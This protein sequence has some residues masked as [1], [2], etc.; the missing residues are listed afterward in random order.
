M[1]HFKNFKGFAKAKLDLS[2]QFTILI[3]PNGAGKSNI[4]EATE[5]LSFIA[6]GG[7]L[8]DITDLG[9]GNYGLHIRG[10]LSACPRFGKNHFSL[11]FSGEYLNKPFSYSVKVQTEPTPLINKENL[12]YDD[13]IIFETITQGTSNDIWVSYYDDTNGEKKSLVSSEQSVL[14]QYQEFAIS[15]RDNIKG[16][17]NFIRPPS[18]F[19][20]EPNPKL[21]RQYEQ[22]IVSKIHP[23]YLRQ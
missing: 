22:Q 14:S 2:K 10:S 6:S 16:I 12:I 1:H 9:R 13:K 20:F 21:M 11:S 15:E 5:L 23:C 7:S 18:P 3:G 4:I 19:V 8:L 17:I